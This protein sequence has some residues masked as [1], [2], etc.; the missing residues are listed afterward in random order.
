MENSLINIL[1]TFQGSRRMMP[2]FAVNIYNMLFEPI[3]KITAY[4]IGTRILDAIKIWDDRILIENINVA[5]NEDNNQYNVKCTFGIRDK[6]E[7]GT[8]VVKYILK[9]E[10]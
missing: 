1:S 10:S 6:T 4:N 9:A 3:D 7:I 5:P 2:S 8:R